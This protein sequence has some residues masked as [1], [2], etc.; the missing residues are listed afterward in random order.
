[1]ARQQNSRADTARVRDT[2]KFIKSIPTIRRTRVK[3]PTRRLT[4]KQYQQLIP[5][6]RELEENDYL[7]YKL[8]YDYTRS[9]RQFE[10]R[11]PTTVHAGVMWVFLR[12]FSEW[13]VKLQSSSNPEVSN[14]AQ[15]LRLH[16]NTNIKFS[17]PRGPEDKISADG[18]IRHSCRLKCTDP[19]LMFEVAWTNDSREELRKKA[20]KYIIGSEGRIQTVVVVYMGEMVAAERKNEARLKKRYR[21][22]KTDKNGNFYCPDEDEKY[23]YEQ[24]NENEIGGVSILVWRAII[25]NNRVAEIRDR[26][27]NTI[28][29]ALLRLSLDDCICNSTINSVKGSDAPLLEISSEAFCDGID[30]ELPAYRRERAEILKEAEV[31]KTKSANKRAKEKEVRQE[32]EDQLRSTREARTQDNGAFGRVLKHGGLFSAR[33]SKQTDK[34]S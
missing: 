20:E 26:T 9:T 30:M 10:I 25:K 18:G 7:D 33:I 29:S 27:G 2:I 32:E 1:M 11:M 12:H 28:P 23:K 6:L 15:T 31:E 5:F 14:A 16:S 24:D 22:M 34:K 3:N 17:F 13:L 8:R 4:P 19:A 21:A